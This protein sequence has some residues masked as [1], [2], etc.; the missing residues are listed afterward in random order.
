[1]IREVTTAEREVFL[2]LLDEFYHSPA[3]LHPVPRTYFE[4]TFQ[5]VT[6][7]SP[8]ARAYLLECGGAPAGYAQLSF[9]YS[10]EAGGRVIWVE[11]LYVRPQYQ[12]RGLGG[13]FFRVL[14]ETYAGQAAR[15]RLEVEPDNDGA[16]RLYGR[17]GFEELPYM[18][19]C[20][21]F[22]AE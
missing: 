14:E 13:A 1:M 15:I 7:G 6:S 22:P 9:T 11:E 16:R 4:R 5:E 19:M 17:V 20:R 18:Q 3:V 2:Q 8:Y 12:G 21:D 10:T